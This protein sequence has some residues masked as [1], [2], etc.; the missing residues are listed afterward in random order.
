[1]N[2]PPQGQSPFLNN[3]DATAG[4]KF[5]PHIAVKPFYLL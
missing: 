5:T 1:M 2:P 3:L 4:W